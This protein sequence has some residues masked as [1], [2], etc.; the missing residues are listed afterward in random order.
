MAELVTLEQSQIHQR[1]KFSI[2]L[3]RARSK[4]NQ[5]VC[6]PNQFR[7]DFSLHKFQPRLSVQFS[8]VRSRIPP[9]RV[10]LYLHGEEEE[11]FI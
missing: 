10:E 2:S 1:W 6:A 3:P 11:S 4:N 9:R 7:R 5:F 8:R